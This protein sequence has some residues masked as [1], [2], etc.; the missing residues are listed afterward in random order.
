MRVRSERGEEGREKKDLHDYIYIIYL[1]V[2]DQ[3]YNTNGNSTF[4]YIHT[5]V[6]HIELIVLRVRIRV[7]YKPARLTAPHI[8]T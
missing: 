1:R 7:H 6:H 8:G 3:L 5:I 4:V 2:T